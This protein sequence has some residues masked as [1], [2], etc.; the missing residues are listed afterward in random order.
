MQDDTTI[1]NKFRQS[2]RQKG[3]P[4]HSESA[5]RPFLRPGF[6]LTLQ[7]WGSSLDWRLV[8]M[9]REL[10]LRNGPSVNFDVNT[11]CCDA[12]WDGPE[13]RAPQAQ[14]PDTD[15]APISWIRSSINVPQPVPGYYA[16]DAE[17]EWVNAAPAHVVEEPMHADEILHYLPHPNNFGRFAPA[18]LIVFLPYCGRHR[19]GDLQFAIEY[20]AS[21]QNTWIFGLS[22]DIALGAR[23]DLTQSGAVQWWADRIASRQVQH[24]GG[25]PPCETWS[26]V[27][28]TRVPDIVVC[29]DNADGEGYG[30]VISCNHGVLVIIS[31][32]IGGKLH[33][34]CDSNP[35]SRV[36]RKDVVVSVNGQSSF[37]EVAA[38]LASDSSLEIVIASRSP[39]VLRDVENLWGLTDLNK[40]ER[41]QTI[42]ANRLLQAILD[43][44]LVCFYAGGSGFVEHPECRG[45]PTLCSI[46]RTKA[47]T[48]FNS[49]PEAMLCAFDQCVFH[50][51]SRKLT[52]ML[53]VRMHSFAREVRSLGNRGRCNHGPG[54]HE[55]T[56]GRDDSGA[57]RTAQL[58]E[59]TPQ[60]NAALARG[61]VTSIRERFGDLSR[62]DI[63]GDHLG[64]LADFHVRV[65]PYS[66][67]VIDGLAGQIQADYACGAGLTVPAPTVSMPNTASQ[68]SVDS[69]DLHAHDDNYD[70]DVFGHVFH[71]D[72]NG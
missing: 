55:T 68:L 18:V 5:L 4:S 46:W 41:L 45:D 24:V 57:W 65:D 62:F 51:V 43:L 54:E 32:T 69:L 10:S 36:R 58:K 20:E 30:S 61:V 66:D 15:D 47:I 33:R 72:D 22:V 21:G 3:I 28:G 71:L 14:L 2:T 1:Y 8:S 60:L 64:D 37:S 34:W 29:L 63:N 52:T 25:G 19:P 12:L 16:R 48:V 27:R 39:R 67:D 23:C 6:S 38:A 59:Y 11:P 7:Y 35:A 56:L 31:I 9:P 44:I 70:E 17:G 26:A 53:L 49:I 42:V 13:H 50:Q 40:H